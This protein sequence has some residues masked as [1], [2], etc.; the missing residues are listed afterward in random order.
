MT[1]VA[2][3]CMSATLPNGASLTGFSATCLGNASYDMTCNLAYLSIVPP[4][5]LARQWL[6]SMDPNAVQLA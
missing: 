6:T 3:L 4:S 2:V 1:M 5:N